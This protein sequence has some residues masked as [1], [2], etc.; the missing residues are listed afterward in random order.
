MK[1]KFKEG[2]RIY[3][4]KVLEVLENGDFRVI[5]GSIVEKNNVIK[6]EEC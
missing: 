6:T 5:D 1:I 3:T 2:V 4:M